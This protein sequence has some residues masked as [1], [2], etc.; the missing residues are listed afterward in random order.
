MITELATHNF[1]LVS[2]SE[3]RNSFVYSLLLIPLLLLSRSLHPIG[4]IGSE[5]PASDLRVR[6][7]V[8]CAGASFHFKFFSL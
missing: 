2:K 8:E 3:V 4:K 7:V 5:Y 6:R 1:F